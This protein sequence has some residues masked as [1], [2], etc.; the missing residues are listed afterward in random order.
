[1]K[2]RVDWFVYVAIILFVGVTALKY[3]FRTEV[4]VDSGINSDT[5]AK[6]T[7][8]IGAVVVVKALESKSMDFGFDSNYGK[9]VGVIHVDGVGV[10]YPKKKA[11][12]IY[13]LEGKWKDNHDKYLKNYTR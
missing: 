8:E 7:S 9:K 2:I 11:E 3:G 6:P 12:T 10:V 4:K 13:D 5:T 1:M